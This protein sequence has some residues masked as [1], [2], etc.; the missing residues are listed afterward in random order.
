MKIEFCRLFCDQRGTCSALN[1]LKTSI[2]LPS[3]GWNPPHWVKST[4]RNIS[5]ASAMGQLVSEWPADHC[6]GPWDIVSSSV[7]LTLFCDSTKM[8]LAFH[9]SDTYPSAL[10]VMMVKTTVFFK[11][12]SRVWLEKTLLSHFYMPGSLTNAPI[13]R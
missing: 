5:T 3:S 1:S 11:E 7:R 9:C 8:L 12:K 10:K 2:A 6:R 4:S 13:L